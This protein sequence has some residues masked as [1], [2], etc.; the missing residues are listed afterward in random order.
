MS[1][2]P[3]WKNRVR[4]DMERIDDFPFT[5]GCVYLFAVCDSACGIFGIFDRF[6]NGRIRLEALRSGCD[7]LRCDEYLPYGYRYVRVARPEEV[8]DFYFLYGYRRC[9]MERS[10]HL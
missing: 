7:D 1:I 2:R 10:R 5:A 4:I 9:E 6:D 8:R 3:L